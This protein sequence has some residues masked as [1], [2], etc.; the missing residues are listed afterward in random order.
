MILY[1][2]S[3]YISFFTAPVTQLPPGCQWD[4]YH[5]ISLI[6]TIWLRRPLKDSLHYEMDCKSC[7]QFNLIESSFISLW[8]A[9]SLKTYMSTRCLYK[10]LSTHK[11]NDLDR[12]CNLIDP[13][14]GRTNTHTH[15]HRWCQCQGSHTHTAL[16]QQRTTGGKLS[17]EELDA[18]CPNGLGTHTHI[19][20]PSSP[21]THTHT[22]ICF[23]I[24]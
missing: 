4:S 9:I 6:S 20:T 22:M 12:K 23:L 13:L 21:H 2:A 14:T 16:G 5:H 10:L 11:N 15:T 3:F 19:H 1:Y 8:R 24:L 18:I 17:W 7:F